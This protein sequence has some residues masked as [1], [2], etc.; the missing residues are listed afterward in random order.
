MS[1]TILVTGGAGFIGSNFVRHILASHD[2][3][4]VV[5]DALK[6]SGNLGNLKDLQVEFV[7]GDIAEKPQIKEVF[8]N[9][10]PN[11][12]VN[13]AAETHVDRSILGPEIF[14]HTNIV[15]T[16]NLLECVKNFQ[17]ERFLQIS[18]DEVYG[19][20]GDN[21]VNFFTEQTP[22][23]PNCPYAATKASGDLLVKSYFETFALPVL[24]TRCTNNYGPFQFPEKLI[25]FFIFRA[26]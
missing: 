18:T 10:K 1:K 11:F 20:L 19:D 3:K 16:Q 17:T 12:A 2:W 4:V 22:L 15:G 14:V 8:K 24:I 25:P 21:S 9:F 13:F 6:Y 23:A 5:F 7:Q 26:L